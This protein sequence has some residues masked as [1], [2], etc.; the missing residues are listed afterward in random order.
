M[1]E[2]VGIVAGTAHHRA[3]SA[4]A[5]VERHNCRCPCARCNTGIT[6]ISQMLIGKLLQ[7]CLQLI[8][9]RQLQALA[10]HRLNG[11]VML[12]DIAANVNLL[13]KGAVYAAQILVIAFFQA[14]LAD[15]TALRNVL[16]QVSFHFILADLAHIAQGVYSQ[17][18]IRIVAN[19]LHRQHNLRHIT[20]LLLDTRHQLDIQII[21]EHNRLIII[22][23]GLNFFL[24]ILNRHI[25]QRA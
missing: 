15:N 16:E 3:H 19:R 6:Q 13:H 10:L 22:G 5:R 14:F 2:P 4:I 18:V 17:L 12:D 9:Q 7:L 8:I 11:I 25:Q 20:A 24:D 23:A 21:F 1:H